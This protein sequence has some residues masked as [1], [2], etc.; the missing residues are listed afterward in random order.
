LSA[1]PSALI[2][3]AKTSTLQ[4]SDV[5]LVAPY[6]PEA[7]KADYRRD[8]QADLSPAPLCEIQTAPTQAIEGRIG[9][10]EDLVVRLCRLPVNLSAPLLRSALPTLTPG[11]LLALIAATG[12]AHHRLIAARPALD[13]RVIKALIRSQTESVA[14]ALV[15]N[16][17][18]YFDEED[19]T[20]LARRGL[21][22]AE[23][24]TAI[25]GHPGLTIAQNQL[26]AQRGEDIGHSN[27]KLVALL[28]GGETAGFVREMARRL[29]CD[30]A[31][32]SSV[33]VS[34]S[35]VPLALT[36][37]AAGLDRAVFLH[38]LT[39]WQAGH[40]GMPVLPAVRKP[41][42]LSVFDLPAEEAQRKL[43][44]LINQAH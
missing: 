20:W 13:R 11:A 25:L 23:L 28:R 19:Q 4:A 1:L 30:Q 5:R 10:D 39:L 15:R 7:V 33:L 17:G 36:L 34:E 2:P 21:E 44:A 27:L 43:A 40:D 24:R 9:S 8:A 16:A 3:E 41:M 26:R 37:C 35:P 12:E 14:L 18:L 29:K 38:A 32:L 22:N 31:S 42:V 6:A